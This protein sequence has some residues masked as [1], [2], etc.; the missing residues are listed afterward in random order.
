MP[1]DGSCCASSPSTP[2]S[3]TS[4]R[5]RPGAPGRSRAGAEDPGHQRHAGDEAGLPARRRSPRRCSARSAPKG[6]GSRASSSRANTVLHG[7]TGQRR[8]RQ[9]RDRPARLDHRTARRKCPARAIELT[10]DAN[11]QQRTEDVLARGRADLQPEGRD[12]DRDGP[13]QRR[14]P[15]ARQLAAGERQRPRRRARRRRCGTGRSASPTNRARPSRRHGLRRAAGRPDHARAA[16]ST[17]RTRSRSPTARSTTTPNTATKRSRPRR[18]SPARATSARSRSANSRAP[19]LQRLGAPLR[20]RRA[21]RRRPARRGTGPD[22][23]RSTSTRAPRWATCRSARASSSR[24]CRWRPPTRRSPTAASCARPTS[25]A[26]S[27]ASRGPLPAGHRVILS[28]PTAAEVRQ[29][30]EGVLGPEGTASE[31]SIPGYALAGKT[32]TA[33]KVDP[34]TGEYSKTDI[35]RLVHRLRPGQRPAAAHGRRRRRT[36]ERL[37]LRRHRRRAG[38]RADHELRAALPGHPPPS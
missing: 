33:S 28:P 10:L 20:L 7:R 29:M 6:R 35:R 27:T 1:A 18:S 34:A 32:G 17:S 12:G 2:A 24:R 13:A 38:L 31:V 16:A 30:L 36:A 4:R 23:A 3:S 9:R 8:G 25:S 26:R 14:D 21:D 37:D 15:R 5:A 11:I 19:P 22:A